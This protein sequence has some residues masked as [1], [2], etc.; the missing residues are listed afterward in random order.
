MATQQQRALK[1]AGQEVGAL[2]PRAYSYLRMSTEEQMSG[3]SYRRQT[4]RL[5]KF[6]NER[7]W[8]LIDEYEDIGVSAYQGL[9]A[10]FGALSRFIEAVKRGVVPQSSFLIVES[11]DRLTRQNAPSA[12]GLLLE[13]VRSGI[14]LVTLDDGQEYSAE[15]LARDPGQIYIAVGALSRAHQESKR[16]SDLMSAVWGAKK[17]AAREKTLLTRTL[18][19][20]L[21]YNEDTKRIEVIEE[22]AAIIRRIF[23]MTRDGYGAFSIA[24]GLN[25]V[26]IE[27]W[28]WRQRNGKPSKWGESYIKKL[29]NGRTVLGEYQPYKSKSGRVQGVKAKPDG[30]PIADYYPAVVSSALHAAANAA[31]AARRG[32]G[33]GRKGLKFNNLFTGLLRCGICGGGIRFI[34]KGKPPKGGTYLRCA[35]AHVR[36]SCASPMFA[37]KAF[38][39]QLLRAMTELDVDSLINA[40]QR[41]AIQRQRQERD[42]LRAQ[43]DQIGARIERYMSFDSEI[44]EVR[45]GISKLDAQRTSNNRRIDELNR[46]ISASGSVDVEAHKEAVSRLLEEIEHSPEDEVGTVAR[47]RSTAASMR[48]VY[49]RIDVRPCIHLAHELMSEYPDWKAKFGVKSKAGLKRLLD[50]QGHLVVFHLRTGVRKEVDLALNVTMRMSSSIKMKRIKTSERLSRASKGRDQKRDAVIQNDLHGPPTIPPK[51]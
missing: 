29:L 21:R 22:R 44:H 35:V 41:S 5:T 38:E 28:G 15:S 51:K 12:V 32:T 9:N 33:A 19:A 6:I 40:D 30:P 24:R 50:D 20:W 8:D 27:P 13:I 43:N 14:T 37:Y 42:E 18:P 23:E 48:R 10:E 31:V 49:E 4:E 26:G 45:E 46:K 16:K 1:G 2:R 39:S 34:D 25:E 3:D 11:M 47:R 7:N 17:K 36:A